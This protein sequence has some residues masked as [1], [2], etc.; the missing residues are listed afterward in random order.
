MIKARSIGKDGDDLIIFGLSARNVE[1]LKAGKPIS[2]RMEELGLRGTVLIMY[3]ETEQDIA[4]EL[5]A[6]EVKSGLHGEPS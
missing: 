2:I 5:H 3:G 6:A 1:L 4:A